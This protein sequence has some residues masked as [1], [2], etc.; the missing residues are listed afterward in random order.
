MTM[1]PRASVPGRNIR[2][3]VRRLKPKFFEDLHLLQV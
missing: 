3:P 1:Q 2:Q